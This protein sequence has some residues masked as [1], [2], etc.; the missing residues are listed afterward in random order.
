MNDVFEKILYLLGG[1]TFIGVLN[2]FNNRRRENRTDF[3]A[4]LEAQVKMNEDLRKRLDKEE[5]YAKDNREEIFKLKTELSQLQFQFN[6][7]ESA[8]SDLPIPFWLKD[9]DGKM[10]ALNSAY[11]REFLLPLGKSRKQYVGNTDF[12][13]WPEDIAREYT[14]NDLEVY[15]SGGSLFF[16][17]TVQKADGENVKYHVIKYTRYVGTIKVGIAGIAIPQKI[18][19]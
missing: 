11:E 4:I 13:M 16:Q 5:K 2:Y 8:H 17:E 14:M 15:E 12:E 7:M 6:M 19:Q 18:F 9:T 10:L 1:G 3:S